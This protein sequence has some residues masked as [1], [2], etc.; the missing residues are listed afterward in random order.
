MTELN[1]Y[2]VR[3][4]INLRLLAD[5]PD[6]LHVLH[7]G[8]AK[9]VVDM[10]YI[11]VTRLGGNTEI[12]RRWVLLSDHVLS[13]SFPVFTA[14]IDQLTFLTGDHHDAITEVLPLLL[15]GLPSTDSDCLSLCLNFSVS[16]RIWREM[17]SKPS[18]TEFDLYELEQAGKDFHDLFVHV[19]FRLYNRRPLYHIKLHMVS[20]FPDSIRMWGAFKNWST[21]PYEYELFI[22]AISFQIT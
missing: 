16:Y 18:H 5:P 10:V 21:T 19:Y 20:H 7:I 17:M 14:P 9:Y 4:F 11:L 1:T 8:L 2:E 13:T 22:Y 6:D 15:F 12:D 3:I